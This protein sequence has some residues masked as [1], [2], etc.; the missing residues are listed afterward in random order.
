LRFLWIGTG[1]DV[2]IAELAVTIKEV[3]GFK[4]DLV[5]N[6][7]K[8]DGTMRKLTD[9]SKLHNLGWKHSI[10]LEDGINRLFNWYLKSK[11]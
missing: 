3:V 8:P 11:K 7:E 6:S 4:G 2:S 10:E 1:K 9:V 5:F